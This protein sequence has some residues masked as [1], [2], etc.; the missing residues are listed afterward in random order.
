MN[1]KLLV[2]PVWKWVGLQYPQINPNLYS[3]TRICAFKKD[4]SSITKVIAQK[5]LCLQTE[6][7]YK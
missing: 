1:N 5:P 6:D 2:P 4:R 7:D 3:E